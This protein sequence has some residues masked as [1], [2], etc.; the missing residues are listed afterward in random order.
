LTKNAILSASFDEVSGKPSLLQNLFTKSPVPLFFDIL[1]PLKL[2]SIALTLA[3]ISFFDTFDTSD[4]SLKDLG[5][6]SLRQTKKIIAAIVA[7]VS[8][9]LRQNFFLVPSLFKFK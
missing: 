8:V 2:L 4:I 3:P 1:T 9:F 6:D 5:I 7:F